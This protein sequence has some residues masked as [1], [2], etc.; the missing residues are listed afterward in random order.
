MGRRRILR[1]ATASGLI[2]ASAL[3]GPPA[4]A[5]RM[6]V[7]GPCA[8]PIEHR[9]SIQ[10][11]SKRLIRCAVGRWPVKGG[12]TKA[13]CIARRESGLIPTMTS[14][15]G[16]YLGLYQHRKKYWPER[17]DLWAWPGWKLKKTA[18]NGRTNTIVTI[19]WVS[20]DGW[21]P[22]KGPGC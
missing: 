20:E 7:P 12:A 5:A 14:S 22:W 1:T 15:D 13:I 9:E 6:R 2:L 8:L 18:L 19:R 21:G 16:K 17:Y 4:H 11:Y 10:H 3:A